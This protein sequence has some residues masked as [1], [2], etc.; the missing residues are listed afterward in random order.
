[1]SEYTEGSEMVNE[2]SERRAT[3]EPVAEDNGPWFVVFMVGLVILFTAGL[4]AVIRSLMAT[5]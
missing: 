4:V 1:M 3:S 2:T 5:F